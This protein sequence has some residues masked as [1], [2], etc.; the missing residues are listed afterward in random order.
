M[1]KCNHKEA[2]KIKTLKQGFPITWICP[3]CGE[4][5]GKAQ[6]TAHNVFGIAKVL[7]TKEKLYWDFTIKNK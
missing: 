7:R 1:K 5:I 2:D 3:K 6:I 4:V